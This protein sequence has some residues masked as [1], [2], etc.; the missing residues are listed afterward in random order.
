[1]ARP[2]INDPYS[3]QEVM[4]DPKNS[5]IHFSAEWPECSDGIAGYLA[6]TFVDMMSRK[7]CLSKEAKNFLN[8]IIEDNKDG[9]KK[10]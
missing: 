5:T 3:M 1:M 4:D 6:E 7:G 10:P 2:R 8:K 9:N